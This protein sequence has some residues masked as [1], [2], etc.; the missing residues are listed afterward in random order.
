MADKKRSKQNNVINIK[1]IDL[2]GTTS[3]LGGYIESNVDINL[4]F[5]VLFLVGFASS[6]ERVYW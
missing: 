2:S 1:N 6:E 3:E 5:I 4:L